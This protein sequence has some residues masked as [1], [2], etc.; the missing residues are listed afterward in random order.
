M[1]RLL[2]SFNLSGP[3]LEDCFDAIN[4]HNIEPV[5]QYIA[6]NKNNPDKI[7]VRWKNIPF[8]SLVVL[9]LNISPEDRLRLLD[10]ILA[11]E[12]IIL[13]MRYLNGDCLLHEIT[14]IPHVPILPKLLAHK[15]ISIN[16]KG[17]RGQTPLIRAT[18][19]EQIGCIKILLNHPEIGVNLTDDD[20]NTAFT[21][22][23]PTLQL[24]ELIA[25]RDD[26][27]INARNNL[28]DTALIR[29]ARN[30]HCPKAVRFL[31]G[32]KGININAVNNDGDSALMCAA[33][34]GNTDIVL[35][36][37]AAHADTTIKNKKGKS[38]EEMAE[39]EWLRDLIKNSSPANTHALFLARRDRAAANP[40]N[41]QEMANLAFASLTDAINFIESNLNK[42]DPEKIN[43]SISAFSTLMM[44]MGLD[45][46]S[47]QYA[48]TLLHVAAS[49]G[50]KLAERIT[51]SYTKEDEELR[52]I[53]E[54]RKYTAEELNRM[55]TARLRYFQPRA[56]NN[57]D[58]SQDGNQ[59]LTRR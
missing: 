2:L 13:D 59:R 53:Q 8:L 11:I 52:S 25:E 28:G 6:E 24:L 29:T 22:A 33:A 23:A 26:V 51:Q 39:N 9:A 18:A 56:D 32:L 30:G 48:R 43:E 14:D 41:R 19:K 20:G 34:A 54:A 21:T 17:D 36:L 38:A 15:S 27:D 55:R 7:N 50:H 47:D 57:S 35:L 16:A 5:L 44:A 58:S 42:I 37:L 31:L 46:K 12:G 49:R 1:H 10:A 4:E 3:T 45:E 40:D